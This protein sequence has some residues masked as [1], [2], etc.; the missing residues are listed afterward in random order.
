MQKKGDNPSTEKREPELTKGY[1]GGG[2]RKK[3]EELL[4]RSFLVFDSFSKI[5]YLSDVVLIPHFL[6]DSVLR[7]RGTVART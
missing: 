4:H 7:S 1:V 6:S 2:G 3:K 5:P